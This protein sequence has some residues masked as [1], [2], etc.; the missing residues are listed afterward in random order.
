MKNQPFNS[1]AGV[2]YRKIQIYM[3]KAFKQLGISFDEGIVLLNVLYHPGTTQDSIADNLVLDTAA[4]ARSL[5]AL[6][7][8]GYLSRVIDEN[9]QRR[10]LVTISPSGA[11][12]ARRINGAMQAWDNIVLSEYDEAETGRIING[13]RSLQERA[14][15]VDISAVLETWAGKEASEPAHP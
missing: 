7:Q 14:A 1:F 8:K 2:Y 10:K 11:E 15:A 5:K 9:N 4:V 12:L 6:E 13:M 3:K